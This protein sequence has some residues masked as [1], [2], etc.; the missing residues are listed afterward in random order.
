MARM[1]KQYQMSTYAHFVSSSPV[2]ARL[3]AQSQI[4][5]G[6]A[7]SSSY[8]NLAPSS[9]YHFDGHTVIVIVLAASSFLFFGIFAFYTKK[10]CAPRAIPTRQPAVDQ[11]PGQKTEGLDRELIETLPVVEYS[12]A[13]TAKNCTECAVCLTDFQERDKTRLLPNCNHAFHPECIDMWLFSHSTCPLCRIILVSES[14]TITIPSNSSLGSASEENLDGAAP[15][16]EVELRAPLEANLGLNNAVERESFFALSRISQSCRQAALAMD[17]R[18][19]LLATSARYPSSITV[20]ER[21]CKLRR[22]CS[23]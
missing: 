7:V 18:E 20:D 17:N 6:D 11:R 4:P 12:A 14:R 15:E 22:T 13:S 10:C 2:I 5:V 9:A 8:S 21:R 23:M 19:R 16:I 3:S 1:S